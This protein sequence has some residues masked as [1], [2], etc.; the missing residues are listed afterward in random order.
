MTGVLRS[1][2]VIQMLQ[3]QHKA[4]AIAHTFSYILIAMCAC[5]ITAYAYGCA[6][7]RYSLVATASDFYDR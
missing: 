5:L 3:N 2:G 7:Q 4:D 1:A 6:T